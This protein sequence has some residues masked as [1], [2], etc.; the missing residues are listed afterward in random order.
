MTT[1]MSRATQ[2]EIPAPRSVHEVHQEDGSV[3]VLRRHGSP[4]GPRLLL[5]HGSGLAMD[6]FYPFWSL[7]TGDFDVLL[8]D[9]RNHGWNAVGERTG[10]NLPNL[11][12]DQERVIE[13]AER[14]YGERPTIGVFHSLSALTALL[15]PTLGTGASERLAAWVLF[16]PP[17]YLPGPKNRDF[18][19]Y[20]EAAAAR[21]TR[22]AES[23]QKRD[24]FAKLLRYLPLLAKAVPGAADLMARTTLRES[25]EGGG[26]ELRCPRDYEAQIA[27]YVRAYTFLVDYENLRCPTKVIGSDPTLPFAFMPT[28]DLSHIDAV[29][30]DFI[31]E[32]THFL[33]V[34]RPA[35]CV[36]IMREFLEERGLAQP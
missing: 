33:Q 11:V 28:Y 22:R 13:D 26:Y 17:L 7:L 27:A 23:F 31:P 9:L 24:D 18:D 36:A 3:T 5:G 2:W 32:T 8:Y 34:E 35:E 29:D 12:R 16:D 14:R 1:G 15:S 21:L 6:F 4:A 20:T 25:S 10:H 30:Y 19:A